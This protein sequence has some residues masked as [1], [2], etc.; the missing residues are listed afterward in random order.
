MAFSR[1]GGIVR[2]S[3]QMLP[4]AIPGSESTP[5]SPRR[6]RTHAQRAKRK[7]LLMGLVFLLIQAMWSIAAL[8]DLRFR[9]PFYA[10]KVRKLRTH[11][12][13]LQRDAATPDLPP[14]VSPHIPMVVMLG[15]SR[16]AMGLDG[17][18]IEQQ[19]RQSLG[20]SV[21]VFNFGIPATGPITHL[22]YL[23]RM[24]AEGVK[25]DLLLVEILPSMLAADPPPGG[26]LEKHFTTPNRLQYSEWEFGLHYGLC[27]P[28]QRAEWWGTVVNPVYAL[29]FPVV[30]R[31][32]P[33]WLPFS[34]RLDAG[35]GGDAAGWS[36]V[37][38]QNPRFNDREIALKR[39]KNDYEAVLANYRPGGPAAE[40]LERIVSLCREQSIPLKL[41]M[42]PEGP[43]FRT[44]YPPQTEANLQ[45][46]FRHL[47]EDCGASL[48]YAREWCAEESFTDS[49]HLNREGAKRYSQQLGREVI[50]PAIQAIRADRPAEDAPR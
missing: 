13:T 8:V 37:L 19:L 24:L 38:F 36:P 4:A 11:H 7:L 28:E 20:H 15:T 23:Q 26:P 29:R 18:T 46:Y 9:D 35:R 25:P 50:A 31:L 43:I 41:V 27:V 21:N 48:V 49:H 5:I 45:A 32:V 6:I 40:A 44:F 34:V 1:L 14:S 3:A 22:L 33:G 30:G 42:M 12:E 47:Q 39:A 10:D 2:R 17:L 16:T